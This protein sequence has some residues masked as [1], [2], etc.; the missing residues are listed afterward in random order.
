MF[1]G[2][3]P[4][5][6]KKNNKI[7]VPK[8]FLPNPESKIAWEFSL[9]ATPCREAIWGHLSAIPSLTKSEFAKAKKEHGVSFY[10]ASVNNK[11]IMPLPKKILEKMTFKAGDKLVF[12]GH[13]A[14][15]EIM[16]PTLAKQLFEEAIQYIK[17]HS[18]DEDLPDLKY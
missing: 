11:R 17:N 12:V 1:I 6:L 7:L 10:D 4:C 2:T 15:F 3:H 14:S 16:T 8:Q 9:C 5:V 13:G 18:E